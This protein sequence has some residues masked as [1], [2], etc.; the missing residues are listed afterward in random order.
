ME[1]NECD[2]P[3]VA[4]QS[5]DATSSKMKELNINAENFTINSKNNVSGNYNFNIYY[6]VITEISSPISFFL[7]WGP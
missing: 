4:A 1:K 3:V 2:S 5:L 6:Y 7:L